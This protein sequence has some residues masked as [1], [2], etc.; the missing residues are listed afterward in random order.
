MKFQIEI[1]DKEGLKDKDIYRLTEFLENTNY[2]DI[3]DILEGG[4][5]SLGNDDFLTFKRIKKL[6]KLIESEG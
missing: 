4:E 2:D 3:R 6:I 1:H 5:I